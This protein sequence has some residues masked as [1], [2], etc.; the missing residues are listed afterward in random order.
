MLLGFIILKMK[1][2]IFK[3]L[4]EKKFVPF[5]THYDWNWGNFPVEVVPGVLKNYSSNCRWKLPVALKNG[6]KIPTFGTLDGYCIY[7][8]RFLLEKKRT[9]KLLIG[10]G[11]DDLNQN[12][13]NYWSIF[14][15]E[16]SISIH[17]KKMNNNMIVAN[18]AAIITTSITPC[19]LNLL[20]F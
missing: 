16:S 18:L 11:L 17:L 15:L 14:K 12:E 4:S 1:S 13:S 6:F 9:A 10:W 7:D 3:V 20:L 19:L 5:R 2:I 8:D